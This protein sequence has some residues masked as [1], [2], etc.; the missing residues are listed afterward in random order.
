MNTLSKILEALPIKTEVMTS[1]SYTWTTLKYDN[2]YFIMTIKNSGNGSTGSMTGYG[3]YIGISSSFTINLPDIGQTEILH[4]TTTVVGNAGYT[5][6]SSVYYENLYQITANYVRLGSANSA[7]G[8]T[9]EV[10]V[11][12][13]WEKSEE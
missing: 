3:T 5:L 13:K 2:G 11:I 7:S 1:G 8:L 10:M 4:T 12:G 9:Y 6:F